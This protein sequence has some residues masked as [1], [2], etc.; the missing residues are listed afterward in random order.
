MEKLF[1][2]FKW[3]KKEHE[4]KSEADSDQEPESYLTYVSNLLHFVI[5]ICEVYS[6]NTM[7]YNANGLY[8]HRAQRSN[9]FIL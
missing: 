8:P 6:N 5:S 9:D 7:A 4:A 2:A 1:L 3:E